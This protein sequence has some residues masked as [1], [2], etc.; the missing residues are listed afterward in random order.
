[1]GGGL[2]AGSR[3]TRNMA[4][5]ARYCVPGECGA[6][7]PG[8]AGPGGPGAER[9]FRRRAAV[10]HG[11]GL[12]G[13]RDLR[14]ARLHLRIAG[15]LPAALCRGRRGERGAGAPGDTGLR[16]LRGGRGRPRAER[17]C[18]SQ[19][20]VVSVVRDAEA[21]LLPGVGAVVTCKVG[22]GVGTAPRVSLR[23]PAAGLCAFLTELRLEGG[24]R[25]GGEGEMR[26]TERAAGPG[27]RCTDCPLSLRAGVQ[28]QLPFCQSEHPVRWLH[29]AEI[30]LPRHHT[31]GKGQGARC[32]GRDAC[33]A[34]ASWVRA[35]AWRHLARP[36]PCPE[37]LGQLLLALSGITFL[38]VLFQE[39]RHSSHREG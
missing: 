12:G 34:P 22:A 19:L 6:V 23:V 9:A 27:P 13:Q 20:P 18:V 11:R 38:C 16:G 24:T 21:Q 8:E 35:A 32:S 31:V 30:H 39:G 10:Q 17:V 36:G 25:S 4:P 28:H 5:P 29:A 3:A 15:R 26:S 2:L 14:A 7:L 1:M 33:L 37:R